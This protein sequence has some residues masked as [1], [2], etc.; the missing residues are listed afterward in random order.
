MSTG[1]RNS[2]ESA[3]IF[4]TVP[5]KKNGAAP[6]IDGVAP[7]TG[8]PGVTDITIRGWHFGETQGKSIVSVGN[9]NGIS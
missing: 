6:E 8:V 1:Q 5:P 2:L 9:M 3:V 4:V 7:A